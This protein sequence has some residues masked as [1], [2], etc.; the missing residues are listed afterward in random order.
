MLSI[1]NA[2]VWVIL[3]SAWNG[4]DTIWAW[5]RLWAGNK[6]RSRMNALDGQNYGRVDDL[7]VTICC[8]HSIGYLLSNDVAARRRHFIMYK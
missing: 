8:S 6:V 1:H 3:A 2:S 4:K 5:A 7:S